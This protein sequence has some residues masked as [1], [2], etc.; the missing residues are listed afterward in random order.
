MK[1]IFIFMC[2]LL[3]ITGCGKESL[4]YKEDNNIDNNEVNDKILGNYS[5]EIFS[6]NTFEYQTT[7]N[8]ATFKFSKDSTFECTYK[9]GITYKGIY[10]VYNG[11][12]ISIKA[13]DIKNDTSIEY[14]Q[15]L[16]TDIENVSNAMINNTG[17]MLNAYLL[18][19][20]VNQQISNGISEGVDIIQ[21]FV[22]SYDE[23]KKT[24]I[25]VNIL[26]K[27][28]GTFILK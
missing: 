24:G 14:A 11:L 3:L 26:G 22:I 16:A 5:R 13:S 15:Q 17:E 10:E 21:P 4:K 9:G 8:N 18:Y 1:K 27:E 7:Y 20:K 19:L 12:Y 23:D 28:Q 6:N 2:V 25:I